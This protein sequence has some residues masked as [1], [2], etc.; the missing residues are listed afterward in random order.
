MKTREPIDGR[1][2][3]KG[4]IAGVDGES[5]TFEDR[6]VGSVTVP[7]SNVAKANLVFDLS[8]ELKRK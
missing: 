7:Y 4:V 5:I 2:A 8:E 3:F 1:K 6:A